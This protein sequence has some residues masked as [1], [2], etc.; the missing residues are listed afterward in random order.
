MQPASHH[1]GTHVSR[2]PAEALPETLLD[3]STAEPPLGALELHERE[4]MLRTLEQHRWN[5]SHMAKSLNV[6]RNTVYRRLHRVRIDSG[7]A[8][9]EPGAGG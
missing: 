7:P 6:S 2:V 5:I 1:P 4:L 9:S 3:G 8:E